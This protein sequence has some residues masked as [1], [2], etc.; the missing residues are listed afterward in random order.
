[1]FSQTGN[2]EK[3]AISMKE[4]LTSEEV[5][6]IPVKDVDPT[7]LSS[8]DLIFLGSG[9][10]ASRIHNSVVNL[11]KNTPSLS[12]KFAFF[13]THQSLVFYQKPFDK[14]NKILEKN[15]CKALGTFDCV[16]ENLGIP[17]ETQMAMLNRLPED[18]RKK[19]EEDWIKVKGRPNKEDLEKAKSF[20][21]TIINK[22]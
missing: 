3:V 9:V 1:Y 14:I 8:Y 17:K 20:A 4:A 19:A 15:D 16:G 12:S 11:I 10:Y 13:C 2:T 5:D 18:Q 22:F 6:L 7:N 21:K